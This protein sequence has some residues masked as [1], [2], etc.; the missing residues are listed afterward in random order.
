MPKIPT[1][2][3]DLTANPEDLLVLEDKASSTTRKITVQDAL[4]DNIGANELTD[5]SVKTANIVTNAVT[6]EK[7]PDKSIAYKKMNLTQPIWAQMSYSNTSGS[8]GLVL[9]GTATIHFDKLEVG[10]NGGFRKHNV[11]AGW[12]FADNA[13][14]YSV[15]TSI[16]CIDVQSEYT[17]SFWYTNDGTNWYQAIGWIY[18]D[19]LGVNRGKY[20]Q[21]EFYCN[22]NAIFQMQASTSTTTRMGGLGSRMN[23]IRLGV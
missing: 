14:W 16:Q 23:I 15:M 19:V 20:Y 3:E 10:T 12:F 2:P 9:N 18:N 7:I 5:K 13:G 22:A 1:Y 17:L 8:G 21:C 4:R 6:A 11:N